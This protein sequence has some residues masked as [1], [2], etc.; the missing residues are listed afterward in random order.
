VSDTDAERRSR[1]LGLKL[2]ALVRD[3]LADESVGDARPFTPGAALRHGDAAW[4]LLDDRPGNMLGAALAWMLRSGA[5]SLHVIAEQDTGVLARRALAFEPPVSVWHADGRSLLPAVP[6]PH[7]PSPDVPAHHEQFRQL[8][9]DA[10]AE[11]Q[12][13]H[14]VLFGDVRGLEV[15]RVVDDPHLGTTRLEVGVGAHDR[16]AFQLMHGDVPTAASLRRVVDI[17]LQ[18]RRL[19]APQHPLNRLAAER[20]V[21][22]RVI[23]DPSL[24]GAVSME[25][26]TPPVPRTNLKDPVPCVATGRD[27]EGRT[28]VAVCAS[29]VDLDLVPYAADARS[30][31]SAAD[32]AGGEGIRLV[33]V[34]PARD[35]VKITGEIAGLLRQPAEFVSPD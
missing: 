24:V 20:L 19:G 33:L 11:P 27:A 7:V 25:A 13:E 34:V 8:I 10:G 6:E 29:G 35:R 14:G 5:S 15:C 23:E 28:V 1:L 16:E 4:V 2:R 31:V 21:R 18:H 22:W 30:A 12:V 26:A 32:P 3:H 17:V 9:S